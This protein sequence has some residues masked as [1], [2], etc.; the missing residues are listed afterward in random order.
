MTLSRSVMIDR[1]NNALHG[2]YRLDRELGVDGM[3]TVYLSHNRTR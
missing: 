1:F 2:R 3:A